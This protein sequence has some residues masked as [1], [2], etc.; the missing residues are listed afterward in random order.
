MEEEKVHIPPGY[1]MVG[2]RKPMGQ[3]VQLPRLDRQGSMFRDGRNF[4]PAQNSTLGPVR[5]HMQGGAFNRPQ[6]VGQSIPTVEMG[7][8]LPPKQEAIP[9]TE[10]PP[11]G[12]PPTTPPGQEQVKS[13]PA[14]RLAWGK[15]KK[16]DAQELAD[17]LAEVIAR[18][19]AKNIPPGMVAQIQAR[20]ANFAADPKQPATA[21]VE[22]T[23]HEVQKMND[24]ILVLEEAEGSAPQ[25]SSTANWLIAVGAAIGLGLLID[26]VS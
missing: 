17:A 4:Q 18:M 26:A 15:L 14:M 10:P 12:V 25:S 9:K 1:A 22:I 23:E 2:T 5:L 19:R 8:T 11:T 20:L 21:E 16:K 7:Q 24:E 6:F 13:H 3:N